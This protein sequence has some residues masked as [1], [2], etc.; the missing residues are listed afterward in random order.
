MEH[1]SGA[2]GFELQPHHPLASPPTGSSHP[3]SGSLS[4]VWSSPPPSPRRDLNDLWPPYSVD[5]TL[6]SFSHTF[7]H[8]FNDDSENDNAYRGTVPLPPHPPYYPTAY[9]QHGPAP[10]PAASRLGLTASHP[11]P[12]HPAP[13]PVSLAPPGRLHDMPQAQTGYYTTST[14]RGPLHQ[15]TAYWLFFT[16]LH[17]SNHTPHHSY[18]S[19]SATHTLCTYPTNPSRCKHG[20]SC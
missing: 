14:Y 19:P 16:S 17:M 6:P 4:L 11:V 12:F 3:Q 5:A 2:S 8:V 20:S 10:I 15:S 1:D 7:G 9:Y 13:P 18:Q